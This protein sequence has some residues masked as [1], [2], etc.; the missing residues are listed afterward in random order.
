M[1]RLTGPAAPKSLDQ[2]CAGTMGL[3]KKE[4]GSENEDEQVDLAGG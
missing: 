3:M 4:V 2:V 1:D